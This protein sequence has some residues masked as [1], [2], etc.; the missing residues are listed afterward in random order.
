MTE[1]FLRR[2]DVERRTGI[3]RSTLYDKMK[4][5]DFPMPIRLSGRC[6]AWLES[7]VADWQAQQMARHDVG[8]MLMTNVE[9][10]KNPCQ[11]WRR[12]RGSGS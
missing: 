2:P 11:G 3:A 4:S 9:A 7:E 5:G 12:G 6:V 10:N 8:E 1:N